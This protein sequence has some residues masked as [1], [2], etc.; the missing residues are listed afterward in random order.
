[1]GI[2]CG[3]DKR[4]IAASKLSPTSWS[5]CVAASGSIPPGI[6]LQGIPSEQPPQG[7]QAFCGDIQADASELV[8]CT[9]ARPPGEAPAIRRL[10]KALPHGCREQA[11]RGKVCGQ[12][13]GRVLGAPPPGSYVW[14][15]WEQGEEAGRLPRPH[16]VH[17]GTQHALSGPLSWWH[18]DSKHIAKRDDR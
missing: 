3:N 16:F 18:S 4:V 1:M 10:L 9:P 11:Q 5:P 13:P 6:S 7:L 8:V 2:R 14:G 15:S 17:G 12:G